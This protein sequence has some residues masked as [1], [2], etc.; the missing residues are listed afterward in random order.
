MWSDKPG[1]VGLAC[2]KR[3][4]ISLGRGSRQ[5]S[6]NLPTD[7]GA[8]SPFARRRIGL[9]GFSTRKVCR[10]LFVAKQ[11]VVSYTTVSPLPACAGGMFSVALS[12]TQS[13]RR[14]FL[15]VR[16]YDA[17]CC[18]DFPLPQHKA[19]AAIRCPTFAAKL[20]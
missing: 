13:S 20:R 7:V 16:K 4:I 8:G 10:A 11:A 5:S 9:F 19:V 1:S 15:P 14:V 2:T 18:P 3:L 12:V 17:L 6:I